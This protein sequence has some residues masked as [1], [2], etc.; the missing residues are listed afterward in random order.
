MPNTDTSGLPDVPDL[1]TF[2]PRTLELTELSMIK[3]SDTKAVLH[4][5]GVFK[6]LDKATSSTPRPSPPTASSPS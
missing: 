1:S 6:L 2:N 5:C 3:M 4:G